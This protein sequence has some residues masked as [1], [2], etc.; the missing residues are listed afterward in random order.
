VRSH[1][2]CSNFL[3]IENG[4]FVPQFATAAKPW[5]CIPNNTGSV[6]ENPPT[7]SFVNG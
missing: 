1:K 5:V 6:P 3:K 4:K 7:F 2:E